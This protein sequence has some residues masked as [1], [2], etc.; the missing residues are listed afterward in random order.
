[1]GSDL[2]ALLQARVPPFLPSAGGAGMKKG[3]R[4]RRAALL[5]A[6]YF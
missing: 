6:S 3:G 4:V 1:M 5:L 2:V